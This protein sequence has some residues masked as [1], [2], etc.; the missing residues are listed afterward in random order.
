MMMAMTII[1][2]TI[3]TQTMMMLVVTEEMEEMVVM[4]EVEMGPAS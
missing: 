4:V 3:L 2:S 1:R